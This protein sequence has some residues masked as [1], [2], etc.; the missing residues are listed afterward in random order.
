MVTTILSFIAATLMLA[1]SPTVCLPDDDGVKTEKKMVGDD[2]SIVRDEVIDGIRYITAAPSAVVCSVRI[3]IHLK[4]D[5]VDS[6]V[7]TRGCNGNAKGIGA[8]IKG[9]KVDEAIRRL[10]GID[11]AGRGTSCPDQL[12]RVLEAAISREPEVK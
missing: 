8:L 11:C 12:A 6:V 7:Y 5:V 10:K 9:M 2:F 3:D 4:G 1:G